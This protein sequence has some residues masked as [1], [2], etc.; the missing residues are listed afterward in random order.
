MKPV[1]GLILALFLI[2][3][4]L[5][6][7]CI[8]DDNPA[9]VPA[10]ER[11]RQPGVLIQTIGDITG[12]GVIL[13]GVPHG[14]IDTVTFTIG[15]APDARTADLNNMTVVYADAVRSEILTPVKGYRGTP[16]P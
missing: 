7:G 14:T 15:L 6:S 5:S 12:Q 11:I 9:P 3:S 16:P 4:A 1:Y 13:Q 8:S 10:G 2:V